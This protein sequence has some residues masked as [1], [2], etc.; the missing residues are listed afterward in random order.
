MSE[1]MRQLRVSSPA[2]GTLAE[3]ALDCDLV[4]RAL[5]RDDAAFEAIMRRNNRRLYR[6]ARGILR[7]D[8]EAED[9][10]QETYV[11]AFA[12][13]ADFK[14]PH[15]LSAWLARIAVNEALGRL[16][17]RGR[18]VLIEDFLKDGG[19]VN[20]SAPVG[21]FGDGKAVY[22]GS[23]AMMDTKMP[24]PERQAESAELR[25]L[26]EAAIDQLPDGF[27]AVFMLRA[28]EQMSIA[29]TAALLGIRPETVKTRF[30]RARALMRK[31]MEA[32]VTGAA[33]AAFPFA[34]ARCDRIV[35]KVLARLELL[36]G[37]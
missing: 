4:A 6:I 12:K 2:T 5:G 19:A 8:H 25:R 35:A 26:I 20:A 31:T 24:N 18:V 22:E 32:Q 16:R 30:H 17:R 28:V 23:P 37:A 14:G 15:G 27:R 13:L 29:E 34:G 1:G 21:E 33:E 36:P 10:V 9:V 11:R 7:S 3:T